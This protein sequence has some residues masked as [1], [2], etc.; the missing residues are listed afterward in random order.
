MKPLELNQME[1]IEGGKFWGTGTVTDCGLFN[2]GVTD[3]CL[4]C[5]QDYMFWIKVGDPYGCSWVVQSRAQ[6]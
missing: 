1:L 2:I 6:V 4:V 5:S 3:S